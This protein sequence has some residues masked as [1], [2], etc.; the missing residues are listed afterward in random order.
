M[1]MHGDRDSHSPSRGSGFTIPELM[2]VVAT[3]AAFAIP[4]LLESTRPAN[5]PR[6]IT[7]LKAVHSARCS[8]RPAPDT[9]LTPTTS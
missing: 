3:V 4:N 5:E 2:I 8:T 6:A 7:C 9:A 1:T